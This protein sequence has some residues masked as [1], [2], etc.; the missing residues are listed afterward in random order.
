MI[1]DWLMM[2]RDKE[3]TSGVSGPDIIHRPGIA[4]LTRCAAVSHR[5]WCQ[6]TIGHIHQTLHA[7]I[8]FVISLVICIKVELLP[9]V[10]IILE[11]RELVIAKFGSLHAAHIKFCLPLA[12]SIEVGFILLGRF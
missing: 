1:T 6:M 2:S 11:F 9:A 4:L 5:Q 10:T 3:A 12:I 8:K 7:F